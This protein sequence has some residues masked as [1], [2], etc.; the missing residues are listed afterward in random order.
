MAWQPQALQGPRF[1]AIADLA[2]RFPAGRLPTVAEL[3]HGLRDL[4][5]PAGISLVESRPAPQ[6]RRRQDRG[7]ADKPSAGAVASH[8]SPLDI[9]EI[10]CAETGQV[11]CRPDNFHDV[12]NALSWAA[13]PRAKWQLTRRIAALQQRAL[14]SGQGLPRARDREHDRLALLDEGGVLELDCADGALAV[15]VGHALW[16]HAALASGQIRAAKVCL[17]APSGMRR[18]CASLG[19]VRAAVDGAWT[20]LVATP[21]RLHDAM[22]G[23]AGVLVDDD[24]LWSA[25]RAPAA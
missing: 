17:P 10:R 6:R 2:A 1:A 14:A 4:L 3:D 13:F 19:E 22:A 23:R 12:W 16:Q 24:E 15:V 21:Q 5:A 11:P 7:R 8:R 20:E 9:Y 18:S 25:P